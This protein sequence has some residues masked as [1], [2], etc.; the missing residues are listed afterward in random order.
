MAELKLKRYQTAALM[1]LSDFLRAA[2]Q[3]GAASAFKFLVG[4]DY[5]PEAF[6]DIPCVCLRIPTGGGKTLMASHAIVRMA[7]E[8]QS[9]DA[10]VAVWLVPSDAIRS[11]TL[12]ALQTPGHPYRVALEDAYGQ[13]VQ[14]CDLDRVSTLVIGGDRQLW[15]WRRYKAS[16]WSKPT[17]AMCMPFLNYSSGISNR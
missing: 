14:V 9:T 10:P 3:K 16:A 11:Q 7:R 13:R 4:R 15:W 12:S 17:R 5:Q 1:A 6:G 2:T 8:W